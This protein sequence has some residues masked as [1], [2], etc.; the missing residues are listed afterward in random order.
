[1]KD[2]IETFARE[3]VIA[4]LGEGYFKIDQSMLMMRDKSIVM[5]SNDTL[6][7]NFKTGEVQKLKEWKV[8]EINH[9]HYSWI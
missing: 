5:H 1:M 8:S 6:K 4:D 3:E 7:S 9:F 2:L